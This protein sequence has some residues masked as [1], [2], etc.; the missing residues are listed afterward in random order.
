MEARRQLAVLSFYHVGL[1]DLT[2][3]SDLAVGTVGRVVGQQC[4]KSCRML[5]DIPAFLDDLPLS[6]SENDEGRLLFPNKFI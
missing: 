2:W 3:V 4:L 6:F 1:G 5:S